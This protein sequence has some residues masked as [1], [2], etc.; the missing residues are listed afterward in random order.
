[1]VTMEWEI[2]LLLW[3]VREAA[4]WSKA[5]LSAFF[6]CLPWGLNEANGDASDDDNEDGNDG[7]R[8]YER[9]QKFDVD[10][11]LLEISVWSPEVLDSSRLQLQRALNL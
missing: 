1:M 11:I 10:D 3:S 5:A 6:A 9:L 8:A 4:G 2:S 7:W